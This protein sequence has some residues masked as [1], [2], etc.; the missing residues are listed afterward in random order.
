MRFTLFVVATLLALVEPMR[1]QIIVDHRTFPLV[2]VLFDRQAV[3]LNLTNVS[4]PEEMPAPCDVQVELIGFDPTTMTGTVLKTASFTLSNGQTQVADLGLAEPVLIKGKVPISARVLVQQTAR[5]TPSCRAALEVVEVGEEG[6]PGRTTVAIG[7]PHVRPHAKALFPAVTLVTG[8]AIRIN[9]VNIG[10]P[11]IS[12]CPVDLEIHDA[13]GERIAHQ[14]AMVSSGAAATLD[15]FVGDPNERIQLRGVG[16]RSKDRLVKEG[17][18]TFLFSME[19]FDSATGI[20]T[21]MMGD[22]ER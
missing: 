11:Q 4:D 12:P 8:Q 5:R 17:C 3:Q 20:T 13:A 10:D 14:Q 6:L 1:A 22:P 2:G 7:D 16:E 21:L 18:D 19:L 15:F 9:A